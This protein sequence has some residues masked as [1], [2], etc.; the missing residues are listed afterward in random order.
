MAGGQGSALG[1]GSILD[2]AACEKKYNQSNFPFER[3]LSRYGCF[4]FAIFWCM[5]EDI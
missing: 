1:S 3:R 4:S 2:A 5:M